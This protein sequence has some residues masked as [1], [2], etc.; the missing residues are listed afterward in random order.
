MLSDTQR[1]AHTSLA[2]A[3]AGGAVGV[4]LLYKFPTSS[5]DYYP[6]CPIHTSTGLLCPGCG[7]TRALEALVHGHL[8]QALAL[9]PLVTLLLPLLLLYCSEAYRRAAFGNA[10]ETAWPTLPRALVP[11]LLGVAT[12]FTVVRNLP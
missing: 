11:M 2:C 7:A 12:L 9:N 3:L 1:S 5:V 8:A 10:G 6:W 4:F